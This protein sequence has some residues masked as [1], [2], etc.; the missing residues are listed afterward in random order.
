MSRYDG[1]D[2]EMNANASRVAV[3]NQLARQLLHVEHPDSPL[4]TNK[5]QAL[6]QLWGQLR[7]KVSQS[8]VMHHG[9]E[10][11]DFSHSVDTYCSCLI[12]KDE[13]FSTEHPEYPV[14]GCNSTTD[15]EMSLEY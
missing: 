10:L 11:I 12:D 13:E 6:N 7:E 8:T 1:F 3:V 14:K 2:K 15:Q 9:S 4:I 5:Q